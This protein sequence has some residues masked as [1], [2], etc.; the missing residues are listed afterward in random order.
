M[1][2][3]RFETED[4]SKP[5]GYTNTGTVD[6]KYVFFVTDSQR[7][8]RTDEDNQVYF[9]VDQSNAL[10]GTLS[11]CI[12]KLEQMALNTLGRLQ[13][14]KDGY[15]TAFDYGTYQWPLESRKAN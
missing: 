11:E 1:G 6:L 15:P 3:S 14:D 2:N 10:C 4:W 8:L 5:V 7:F 13:I 12:P 9:T